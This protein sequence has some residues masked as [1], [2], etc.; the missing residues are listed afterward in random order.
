VGIIRSLVSPMVS[1]AELTAMC[2]A[3]PSPKSWM[4]GYYSA[5][6]AA[7]IAVTPDTAM[8]S[9]A[10]F[11]AVRLYAKTIAHAAAQR[12]QVHRPVV[13]KSLTARI[14]CTDFA[15]P[16]AEPSSKT[17]SSSAHVHRRA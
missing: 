14:H 7:G 17:H 5:I 16:A 2:R 4:L 6:T 15:T 10:V 11:S 12:V 8:R 3:S 9:T 1:N 13:A